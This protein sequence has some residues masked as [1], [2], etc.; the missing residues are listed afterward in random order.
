MKNILISLVIASVI[1]CNQTTMTKTQLSNSKMANHDFL[2][3]M[4]EDPYFPKHLVQ[5]G[6]AILVELCS[7]I[8]SKKPQNLDELYQLTHQATDKF[9]DLSEEFYK[10][11]SEIETVARE[12]IAED[13]DAI[14]VAYGFENADIEELIAT[15]DW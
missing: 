11:D 14:S 2:V 15:R 6:E 3:G 13:F 9:N 4:Y 8:E 10:N 12:V 1:S 7:Q 5:K